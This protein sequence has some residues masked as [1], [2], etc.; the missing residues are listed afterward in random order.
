VTARCGLGGRTVRFAAEPGRQRQSDWATQRTVIAGE[1]TAVHSVVNTSS[2]ARRVH[3]WCTATEEA[4][5]MPLEANRQ[6]NR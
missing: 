5:S 3:S 6:S 1:T 2:V 4:D